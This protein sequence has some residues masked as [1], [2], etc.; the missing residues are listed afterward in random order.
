M[1]LLINHIIIII[2]IVIIIIVITCV[3]TGLS[4]IG[5]LGTCII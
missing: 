5:R 2:I 4:V 3:Y 1:I